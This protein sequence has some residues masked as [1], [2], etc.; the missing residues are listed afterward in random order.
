[1][2]RYFVGLK[3][4]VD[5][6]VEMDAGVT[7]HIRTVM[8]M[9]EGA[10][11][12]VVDADS[13]LFIAEVTDVSDV[14]MVRIVECVSAQ[15]ELPV[16]A[17]IIVPLLKGDKLDWLLQ[18]GT[19]LGAHAFH[20]YEAERAVVKLDD[21]KRGKRK[22]RFEKIVKEASEQSKR[23][24]VPEIEF[25]GKLGALD[26]DAYGRLMVAYEGAALDTSKHLSRVFDDVFTDVGCIFGPEG[27]FSED[28]L[29]MLGE[30]ATIRLG[31]RILRAETAPLYF[32]SAL[33]FKYED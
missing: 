15:T 10:I 29:K 22:E 14:V 27:G 18:K 25:I 33:S 7:H 5:N 31:P 30:A 32:L 11:V 2:Q 16:R 6:V 19:E 13:E 1:M 23:L 4:A 24:R 28:E 3:L 9:N 26:P 8:R 21:K 20:I 17:T 12:E